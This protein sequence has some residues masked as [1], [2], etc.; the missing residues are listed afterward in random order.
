MSN[1]D[2]HHQ[3]SKEEHEHARKEKKHEE[4]ER[5]Q[6]PDRLPGSTMPRT[7]LIVGVVLMLAVL[8]VWTFLI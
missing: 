3:H 6:H 5:E 1:H 7:L 2:Q 8:L 4:R